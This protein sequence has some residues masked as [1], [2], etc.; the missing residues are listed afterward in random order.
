MPLNRNI[1]PL[2]L[3]LPLLLAA[4]VS[5]GPAGAATPDLATSWTTTGHVIA[6][7][8]MTGDGAAEILVDDPYSGMRSILNGATGAV[9]YQ[10]PAEFQN[11][12]DPV[13]LTAVLQD[14]DGDGDEELLLNAHPIAGGTPDVMSLFDPTGAVPQLW[15]QSPPPGS[16]DGVVFGDLRGNG[17]LD[18][19]FPGVRVVD[20]MTGVLLYDFAVD[21]PDFMVESFQILNLDADSA[22]EILV[23]AQPLSGPETLVMVEVTNASTG[24]G[25]RPDGPR[26]AL[27]QNA[28]NP[29]AGPTEI[30]F[31]VPARG[32][33]RLDVYDAAGRRVRTLVDEVLP[34]GEQRVAWDGRD[35]GGRPV[36]AGVYFYRVEAGGE[37]QARRMV[38]IR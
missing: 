22:G 33:A 8:D 32:P 31:E 10:L 21:H 30:R 38:R 4:A 37:R 28:P 27:G 20:W 11:G 7:G 9:F 6:A 26:L 19:I 5:P 12:H 34:A 29:F 35:S 25:A 17:T 1:R 16:I 15:E 24:V 3:L 14:V 18:L 2:L 23:D 36:A 13:A